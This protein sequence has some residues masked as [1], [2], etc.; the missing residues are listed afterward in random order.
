MQIGPLSTFLPNSE[1]EHDT[2][3]I[4]SSSFEQRCLGFA[5]FLRRQASA[6]RTDGVLMLRFDDRGDA[7]VR[8]R[9]NRLLPELRSLAKRIAADGR[10]DEHAMDPFSIV[11]AAEF[12]RGLFANM[13]R[14]ASVVVDISTISKLHVLYILQMA[15]LSSRVSQLRLVYTRARYGRYDTLSW[16][17]EEPIVVPGFGQPPKA[18]QHLDRLILFCGL[19]PDRCY[20]IWRRFGQS[21]CLK[22]F[23]DAGEQDPDRCAERS[24]RLN[25]FGPSDRRIMLPAFEP[26]KVETLLTQE[27]EEAKS[28]NEYLYIA[29]MTTKWE[30]VAAWRFMDRLGPEGQAGLVYV[31]PGRLNAS[32]HT[33]DD[34]GECLVATVW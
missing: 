1:K 11:E 32:G 18:L 2:L 21:A 24:E 4:L 23:I 16:G 27:Y 9:M 34:L 31:V 14:G 3:V 13:R 6:Y 25:A 29:P 17:A 20:S 26:G 8:G 30:I 28:G 22:V 10:V 7:L 33:R 15:K 5:N 12:Y 19:E